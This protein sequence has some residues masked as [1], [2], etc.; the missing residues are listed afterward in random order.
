MRDMLKTNDIFEQEEVAEYFV[1]VEIKKLAAK[2][3]LENIVD[4]CNKSLREL[5]HEIA[6]RLIE[7]YLNQDD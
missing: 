6:T 4:E 5:K 2:N 1:I 7:T 3:N